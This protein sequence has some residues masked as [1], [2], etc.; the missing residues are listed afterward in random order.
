LW[1]HLKAQGYITDK[2][3]VQDVEDRPEGRHAGLP[4]DFEAQRAQ[5]AGVLKKLSGKLEVK[6][7]DERKQIAVRKSVLVSPEFKALWDRIKHKTTY[8]VHFDNE[9]LIG[10]ASTP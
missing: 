8:R 7:A 9:K 10:S 6:N 4:A 3:K 5:I 1:T 2:G